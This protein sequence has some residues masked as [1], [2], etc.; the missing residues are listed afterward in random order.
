[1]RA[2]RATVEYGIENPAAGPGS[3]NG[4]SPGNGKA[5]GGQTPDDQ[6]GGATS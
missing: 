5:N 6:T 3:D 2:R 1:L 4:H